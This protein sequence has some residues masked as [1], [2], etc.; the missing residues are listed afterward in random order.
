DDKD[1]GFYIHTLAIGTDGR[2]RLLSPDRI[3]VRGDRPDDP[4]A[5]SPLPKNRAKA[6]RPLP[7][8]V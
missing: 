2:L 8:R 3:T 4:D 5:T 6:Q 1:T 7:K